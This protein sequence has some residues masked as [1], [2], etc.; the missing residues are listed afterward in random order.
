M[1]NLIYLIAIS[2][3]FFS[4]CCN[5]GSKSDS[6]G[7]TTGEEVIVT[8]EVIEGSDMETE[9]VEEEEAVITNCDEFLDEYEAWITDYLDLLEMFKK[10][11]T[12]PGL[13]QKY[14]TISQEASTWT[15][16]WIKFAECSE[17]EE[18]QERF[19]EISEMVDKKMEELNMN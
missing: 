17:K 15:Q 4:S 1:K 3:F 14:M 16:Q 8:E 19:D 13:S 18:Y 11:P 10:N 2:I 5:D 7:S 9:A 12:D 6:D